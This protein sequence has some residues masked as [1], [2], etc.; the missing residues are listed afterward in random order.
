MA[1]PHGNRAIA[2]RHGEGEQGRG[3]KLPRRSPGG[4]LDGTG[5]EIACR[6]Q[7]IV[8]NAGRMQALGSVRLWIGI[9]LLTGPCLGG[10]S[11]FDGRTF[12]GWEGNLHYFRI[13]EGVI[14]GGR[15]DEAIPRNEFLATEEE[16]GDFELRL[17]FRLTGER[18]NA[19]IQIRS[20]RIPDSHEM[21]GYQADLGPGICGWLYDESR[22]RRMLATCD[23]REVEAVLDRFG[24][25]DYVIRCRGRRIT[26]HING[27]RTVDYLEPDPN[28]EQEG[29]IALQIHS[30]PPG[31][32]RYRNIEI[33]PLEKEEASLAPGVRGVATRAPEEV[34]IDGNPEEFS[35]AFATPIGYFK[36]N[37]EDR[38]AQF[39]YMW[40]E[41]AFYA[42][43]RTLDGHPANHAPHD[44]IWEG[45]GVEWYFD[46]RRGEDF[47]SREWTDGAVHCYW[48]GL[49]GTRIKPRFCLRPGYLDAIPEVGID[50]AARRTP[51]GMDM[52]FRLPWANFPGF[53]AAEGTVIGIDAELCYSDGQGRVDRDFVYG[54]PLSVQQPAN[55]ARIQLVDKL[56]R[57]H[58]SACSP[59]MMPLRCDTE[60]VQPG[61]PQVTATLALPPVGAELAEQVLFRVT[62][63]G[64]ATLLETDGTV[65]SFS[66][67]GSFRRARARWPV[68]FTPPGGHQVTAVILDANRTELGR[69][70]PRMVSVGMTRGH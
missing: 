34:V 61:R 31:E 33:T 41:T 29:H 43:L 20:R 65:E 15:L 9:A 66:E 35:Q 2:V 10:E 13:E 46:T 64:G 45:D 28:I 39:F 12:D 52:E 25:N 3:G 67:Y 53:R 30:G 21:I 56:E 36:D 69:I 48:T 63:V 19:G 17:Q 40:D 51:V 14:V 16:Y 49:N 4:Y 54:G 1:M 23:R 42:A 5:E 24:W 47:R 58:W 44:R 57:A 8:D 22:R 7:G 59:V 55:L 38:A 50:V 60:W 70:A 68:D 18:T 37:V 26:L 27:L 32:V 11:L 62:D 6:K